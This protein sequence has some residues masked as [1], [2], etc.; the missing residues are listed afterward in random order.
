MNKWIKWG[1]LTFIAII[2][3]FFAYK[4]LCSECLKIELFK[5]ENLKTWIQSFGPMAVVV[6]VLLYAVNT[7]TLLPPIAV[8][9][10]SAGVIFGPIIG[11]L[12]I[13]AGALLGTTLTF[14]ISRFLGTRY[15][16]K[17]IKGKNI[18]SFQNQLSQHGFLVILPIRLIGFPPWEFVN[19]ASGLSKIKYRDY[20][21]ATMIGILPATFAQT[22]FVDRLANF[23]WK[24][25]ALYIAVAAFLF[26]GY[27]AV[28]LGKKITP[29]EA[30]DGEV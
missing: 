21:A 23:N 24:D 19:Y 27:A 26:V 22:F 2:I 18:E 6:F 29:K 12:A 30:K 14:F 4:Y 7:I 25:P 11:G 8:M 28:Y 15:V 5:P 9:S 10:L 20:I 3:G 13:L 16:H 1:C 17:M